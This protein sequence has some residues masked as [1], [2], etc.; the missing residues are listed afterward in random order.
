M[1]L[2]NRASSFE[3]ISKNKVIFLYT[4]S[5]YVENVT[6]IHEPPQYNHNL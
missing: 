2:E 1:V 5:F 3:F 4:A 6:L